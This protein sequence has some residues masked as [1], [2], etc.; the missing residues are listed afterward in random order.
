M[1][2]ATGT[3]MTK[4]LRVQRLI[5]AGVET[6]S[7]GQ[8]SP[9][10][11]NGTVLDQFRAELK[12]QFG[13]LIKAWHAFDT[14]QNGLLSFSEFQRRHG[15]ICVSGQ[16]NLRTLWFLVD[17]DASGLISFH[18]LDPDMAD[19]LQRFEDFIF[20]TCGSL[21]KGWSYLD[22]RGLGQINVIEFCTALS[23]IE[24]HGIPED[25][26]LDLFSALTPV[27]RH[28]ILRRDLQFLENWH[29]NTSR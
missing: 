3:L 29:P 26:F 15:Q 11:L 17:T 20:R 19:I 9:T 22:A 10:G 24:G 12:R 14:D 16:I 21:V 27:G 4:K 6:L 23:Q 8:K 1:W 5:D 18:E 28:T 25:R 7:V 2:Y 13:S